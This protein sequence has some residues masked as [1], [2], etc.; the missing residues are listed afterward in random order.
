MRRAFDYGKAG[1]KKA[2]I[3][4]APSSRVLDRAVPSARNPFAAIEYVIPRKG[5]VMVEILDTNGN[6]LE[7]IVN[8]VNEPGYHMA[9]WNTSKYA[10]GAYK[11]RLRFNDFNEVRDIAL[12]KA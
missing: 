8:A 12:K 9:A 3:P 6:N 5:N 1:E 7:V 10:S 4:S 11:Y 2:A